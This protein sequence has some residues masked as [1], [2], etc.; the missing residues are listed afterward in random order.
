MTSVPK[1]SSVSLPP[2]A[3]NTNLLGRLPHPHASL[4]RSVSQ[5]HTDDDD[6]SLLPADHEDGRPYVR[7]Y[8]SVSS[9]STFRGEHIPQSQPMQEA[10]PD[11]LGKTTSADHQGKPYDGEHSQG[12]DQGRIVKFLAAFLTTVP[13]LLV[14][15]VLLH[16][17]FANRVERRTS[18]SPNL[19]LP[20]DTDDADAYLVNFSA[21]QLT[22]LASWASNIATL[23][24]GFLMTLYSHHLASMMRRQSQNSENGT[25]P[26][27][28]QLGLLLEALDAK[29]TSLWDGLMYLSWKRRERMNAVVRLAYTLLLVAFTLR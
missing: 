19:R 9:I 28:Y 12:I 10:N 27:P 18:T 4:Q 20:S 3:E 7:S 1:P 21:T 6:P 23:V 15:G 13:F 5:D 26:T 2:Q 29:L 17:I 24:P 14:V 8:H 22:T 16:L 25:L 11:L